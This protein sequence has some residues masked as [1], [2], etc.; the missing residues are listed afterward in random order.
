MWT[1]TTQKANGNYKTISKFSRFPFL[2]NH[3]QEH[4]KGLVSFVQSLWTEHPLVTGTWD[5]V[6]NPSVRSHGK[7]KKAK[8]SRA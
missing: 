5:A 4:I 6:A 1:G 8:A 3:Q 2:V 7:Q